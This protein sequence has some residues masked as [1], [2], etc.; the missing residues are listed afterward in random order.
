M[1]ATGS[2]HPAGPAHQGLRL[3]AAPEWTA[4]KGLSPKPA[5][6]AKSGASCPTVSDL[7][8]EARRSVLVTY[9]PCCAASE[10]MVVAWA[11][12]LAETV[13]MTLEERLGLLSELAT[14]FEGPPGGV[15]GTFAPLPLAL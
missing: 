8:R 10:S 2:S 13:P 3:S 9:G 14:L 15:A 5:L 12:R 1:T 11:R 7:L 6:R 4:T